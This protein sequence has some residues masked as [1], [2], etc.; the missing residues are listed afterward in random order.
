MFV[1]TSNPNCYRDELLLLDIE[2]AGLW[3][4]E[5]EELRRAENG[6]VPELFLNVRCLM[7]QLEE[8]EKECRQAQSEIQ[9]RFPRLGRPIDDYASSPSEQALK[10]FHGALND[11][12]RLAEASA[13]SG[14]P[15]R[16]EW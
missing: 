14:N 10:T 1:K 8:D 15:I 9:K 6:E 12:L 3:A 2:R 4:L 13:S 11:V 7:D 5:A 16:M